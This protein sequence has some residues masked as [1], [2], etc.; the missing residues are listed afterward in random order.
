[1]LKRVAL[2]LPPRLHQAALRL[3]ACMPLSQ[4]GPMGG[5]ILRADGPDGPTAAAVAGVHFHAAEV[6]A[7]REARVVRTE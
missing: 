3:K 2:A 4:C 6:D 1:M 5:Q 7:P